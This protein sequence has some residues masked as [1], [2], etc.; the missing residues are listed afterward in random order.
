M[1]VRIADIDKDYHGCSGCVHNDD[2]SCMCQI[3]SCVHAFVALKECYVPKE[4]LPI[5]RLDLTKL[6]EFN[7]L[8]NDLI[9][10]KEKYKNG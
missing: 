3:R 6:K 8:I 2:P 9:E 5:T 4:C 10:L 7:E 1:S